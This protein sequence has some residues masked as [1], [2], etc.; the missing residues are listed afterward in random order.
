MDDVAVYIYIFFYQFCNL[1]YKLYLY[2]NTYPPTYKDALNI[3]RGTA[4]YCTSVTNLEAGKIE[5]V[6]KVLH[7]HSWW[8]ISHCNV[9]FLNKF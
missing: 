7:L 3:S 6:H 9:Q 4:M 5:A 2:K 8:K 1:L